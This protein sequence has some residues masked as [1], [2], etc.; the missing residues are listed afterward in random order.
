M[1]ILF[2]SVF[3]G[4]WTIATIVSV[5]VDG[6]RLPDMDT[7][8]TFTLH[9]RMRNLYDVYFADRRAREVRQTAVG[10]K[11]DDSY[12]ESK[13]ITPSGSRE[14]YKVIRKGGRHV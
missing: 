2:L 1:E 13:G 10:W 12:V 9:D 3:G 8:D 6:I 11:P 7:M 14:Y 4:L 5:V